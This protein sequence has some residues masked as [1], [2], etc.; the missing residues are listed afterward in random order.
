MSILKYNIIILY[1]GVAERW[2][3]FRFFFK[4]NIWINNSS[5]NGDMSNEKGGIRLPRLKLMDFIK[6]TASKFINLKD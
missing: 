5:D 1:N 6:V 3:N 2:V 4:E